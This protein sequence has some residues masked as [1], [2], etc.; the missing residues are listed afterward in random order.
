M[1]VNF[2]A[3]KNNFH[4]EKVRGIEFI[5]LVDDIVT[6][7][8]VIIHSLYKIDL[9]DRSC[10]QLALAVVTNLI[11]EG[12]QRR[13]LRRRREHREVRAESLRSERRFLLSEFVGE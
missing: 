3:F 2:N 5:S 11:T 13:E 1:S 9:T 7:V 4:L 6:N 12:G 8:D 10:L